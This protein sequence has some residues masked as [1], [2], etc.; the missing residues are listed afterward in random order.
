MFFLFFSHF[1]VTFLYVIY[2]FRSSILRFLIVVT[3]LFLFAKM[4]LI[5]RL[6]LPAQD[7]LMMFVDVQ[8]FKEQFLFLLTFFLLVN[9][10]F[11]LT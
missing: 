10:D 2:K 3:I 1:K 8:F 5:I 7:F 9:V 6:L 11:C 4:F